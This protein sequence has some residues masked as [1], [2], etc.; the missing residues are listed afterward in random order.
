MSRARIG[1]LIG[2]GVAISV[3]ASLLLV[4][5]NDA[6]KANEETA[7]W[8]AAIVQPDRFTRG[9]PKNA[10]RFATIYV[11]FDVGPRRIERRLRLTYGA[12]SGRLALITKRVGVVPRGPSAPRCVK[13]R[14]SVPP[15]MFLTPL[16][17]SLVDASEP[18]EQR[19]KESV[20]LPPTGSCRTIAI[21]VDV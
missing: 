3:T 8:Q 12:G 18:E 15:G 14:F 2:L 9:T 16:A 13:A 7:S 11:T 4:S 1:A 19:L 17:Q 20:Y 10:R 5:R 21:E 6:A